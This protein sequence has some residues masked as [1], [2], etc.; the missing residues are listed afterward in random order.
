MSSDAWFL[1]QLVRVILPLSEPRAGVVE[2][3]TPTL[4]VLRDG[5][6]WVRAT[7]RM[8]G[9]TSTTRIEPWSAA[10]TRAAEVKRRKGAA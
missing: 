8:Y 4:V 6:R 3:L 7:G 1:G 2:R 5:S 10:H 9:V